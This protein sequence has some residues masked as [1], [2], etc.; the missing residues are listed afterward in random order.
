MRVTGLDPES[1]QADRQVL[2]ALSD[3]GVRLTLRG[4]GVEVTRER[5]AAFEFDLTDAPDLLPPLAAL[6]SRCEGTTVIRNTDRTIHK[7]SNRV[8]AIAT[9]FRKLG[10]EVVATGDRLE[11]TGGP[12][13]GGTG[14]AHGDHRVAM[15]LAVA[16]T[17]ADGPVVIEGAEHVA[18]S[19]PDF[20][21][22]LAAAGAEVSA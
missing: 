8:E 19:Y 9:E 2:Q 18:K 13:R 4:D 22:D 5:L 16:G 1:V 20:F 11:I 6:A 3:A 15:A 17:A 21:D 14:D 12:V 7:E 10:V